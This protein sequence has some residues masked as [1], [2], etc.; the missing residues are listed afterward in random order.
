[1]DTSNSSKKPYGMLISENP[2]IKLTYLMQV[3]FNLWNKDLSLYKGL[4][5]WCD[6]L[7]ERTLSYQMSFNYR[8]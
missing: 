5:A 4:F 2:F 6:V 3:K 1:M 7:S 8:H